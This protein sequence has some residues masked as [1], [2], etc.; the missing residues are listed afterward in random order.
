MNSGQEG[1]GEL[2]GAGCDG[3]EALQLVE[4]S[5][6]EVA[7]PIQGKIGVTGRQPIRL[8]GDT[9][10]MPRASKATIMASPS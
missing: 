9:G 5:L 8:G 3:S 2:V 10:V 6:D 7:F 1:A 4:E